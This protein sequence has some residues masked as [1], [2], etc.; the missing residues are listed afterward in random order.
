MKPRL[1]SN[2][3][4][5]N[6]V[7]EYQFVAGCMFVD[8]LCAINFDF[9]LI[10]IDT[11]IFKEFKRQWLGFK[12]NE[13]RSKYLVTLLYVTAIFQQKTETFTHQENSSVECTNPVVKPIS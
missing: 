3:H 5:Q 9:P 13:Q 11:F 1:V 12:T 2:K 10:V 8:I 7:F 6:L 4:S